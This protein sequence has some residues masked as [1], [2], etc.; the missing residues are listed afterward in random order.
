MG[1]AVVAVELAGDAIARYPPALEFPG[2]IDALREG[3][4]LV[5]VAVVVAERRQPLQVVP[6]PVLV[7][8]VTIDNT[9]APSPPASC[10]EVAHQHLEEPRKVE[11]NRVYSGNEG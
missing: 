1:Q 6:S 4:E 9:C 11:Y 10:S 2:Q 3:G 7:V 5:G 8:W